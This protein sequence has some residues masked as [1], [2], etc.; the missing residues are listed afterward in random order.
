MESQEQE[1]I[2]FKLTQCARCCIEYFIY[3][4][5]LNLDNSPMKNASV[6]DLKRNKQKASCFTSNMSLFGNS[7]GIII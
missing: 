1:L 4:V 5:T 7:R 2:F 3:I 6:V